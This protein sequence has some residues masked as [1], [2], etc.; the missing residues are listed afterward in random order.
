MAV[1][2]DLRSPNVP[3]EK[4]KEP[5]SMPGGWKEPTDAEEGANLTLLKF[6]G[7]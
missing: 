4:V 7:G 5:A 1:S 2:N 6:D 3:R